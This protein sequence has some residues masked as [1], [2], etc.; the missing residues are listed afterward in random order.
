MITLSD[1]TLGLIQDECEGTPVK[2][3]VADSSLST[4]H[5]SPA[6]QASLA[7]DAKVDGTGTIMGPQIA[8]IVAQIVACLKGPK[9]TEKP[10][11]KPAK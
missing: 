5:F 1:R 7:E 9:V 4:S 6:L 3:A 11:A 8:S 10:E 2:K